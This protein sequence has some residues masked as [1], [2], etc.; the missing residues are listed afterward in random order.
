MYCT[1]LEPFAL[2][3]G[4]LKNYEIMKYFSYGHALFTVKQLSMKRMN[5]EVINLIELS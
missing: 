2:L 1:M 4:G 3:N 5:P